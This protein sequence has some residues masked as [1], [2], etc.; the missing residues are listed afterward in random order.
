M[1]RHT[2]LTETTD[3][4]WDALAFAGK[5]VEEFGEECTIEIKPVWEADGDENFDPDEDVIDDKWK[6]KILVS[7]SAHF[8]E[9]K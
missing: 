4:V 2:T 6:R 9:E 5:H 1:I 3:T 7:I 8:E